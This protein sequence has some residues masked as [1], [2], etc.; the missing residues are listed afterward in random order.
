[1]L[2]KVKDWKII[3]KEEYFDY[4]SNLRD[5]E[6]E[7]KPYK[8]TR[9]TEQNRYYRW[10]LNIIEKETWIPAEEIHEKMRMK[11][12]YVPESWV[13]LAYARS[14]ATLKTDEFS[15]YIEK[16]KNFVAQYGIV[17]PDADQYENNF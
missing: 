3:N 16:I 6:Y 10:L 17:L 2:V 15:E 12:L 5:W 13:Q 4:I 14:T 1:M 9:S 11:F 8:R 7:I